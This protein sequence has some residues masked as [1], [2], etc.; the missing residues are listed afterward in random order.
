MNKQTENELEEL[1]TTETRAAAVY[2]AGLP[3]PSWG[4]G[5]ND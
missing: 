5:R 1:S 3:P 2:Y 4:R